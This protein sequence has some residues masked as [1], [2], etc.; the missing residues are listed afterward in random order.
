MYRSASELL[1]RLG[2]LNV[3]PR[4][5]NI[6]NASS[7][8]AGKGSPMWSAAGVAR[9]VA[10]FAGKQRRRNGDNGNDDDDADEEDQDAAGRDGGA[11]TN[12]PAQDFRDA[13]VAQ[14]LGFPFNVRVAAV[15][16]S[17]E[18]KLP[19]CTFPAPEVIRIDVDNDDGGAA[20]GGGTADDV[21]GGV[22]TFEITPNLKK[23]CE[24][25]SSG[26]HDIDVLWCTLCCV[27]HVRVCACMCASAAHHFALS[28]VC[29][30]H[31]R[32]DAG[33]LGGPSGEV[34]ELVASMLPYLK[35][36]VQPLY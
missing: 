23:L 4:S 30:P 34:D 31:G 11:N 3:D 22:G 10:R 20:V 5:D 32:T 35:V 6:V 18:E 17:S 25:S 14:R 24:K 15:T 2:H 12:N 19:Q 8:Q 7:I 27:G 13:N 26:W 29:S 21:S 36:R 9:Q 1:L 16:W 28:R 33:A